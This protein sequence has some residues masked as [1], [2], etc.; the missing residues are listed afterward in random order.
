VEVCAESR[1]GLAYS[2]EQSAPQLQAALD[3]EVNSGN[4]YR[5]GIAS[6]LINATKSASNIGASTTSPIGL[7][8]S[9]AGGGTGVL[10]KGTQALVG[11]YMALRGTQTAMQGQLQ[12]ELLP[13]MLERD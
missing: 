6:F 10:A 11:T 1:R 13:D 9:V 4:P 3:H 12:N 7:A 8:T 5:A 2:M